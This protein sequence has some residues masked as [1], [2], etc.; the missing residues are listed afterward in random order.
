[1]SKERFS[2]RS[3]DETYSVPMHVRTDRGEFVALYPAFGP[4]KPRRLWE[5]MHAEGFAE[6]DAFH[7]ISLINALYKH[8]GQ[9]SVEMKE[10]LGR[11]E[12]EE[13][14]EGGLHE[15]GDTPFGIQTFTAVLSDPHQRRLTFFDY[16]TYWTREGLD[17]DALTKRVIEKSQSTRILTFQE[18]RTSKGPELTPREIEKSPLIIALCGK[19]GATYA[20]ELVDKT[21]SQLAYVHSPRSVSAKKPEVTLFKIY[22]DNDNRLR[23]NTGSPLC[24]AGYTFGIKKVK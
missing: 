2:I 22:I 23:F 15:E 9:E 19:E 21:S 6:P 3:R 13:G 17:I 11:K 5:S 18:A 16:P 1:M 24:S 12:M 4:D 8:P 20:A 7:V 10:F 14:W